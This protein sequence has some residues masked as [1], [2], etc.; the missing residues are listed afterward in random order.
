MIPEFVRSLAR[1]RFGGPAGGYADQEQARIEGNV[2]GDFLAIEATGVV[3]SCANLWEMAG[4]GARI[5]TESP[6]ARIRH[7]FGISS[8]LCWYWT[9]IGSRYPLW[10]VRRYARRVFG[11]FQERLL[12]VHRATLTW[13]A[14]G[15]RAPTSASRRCSVNAVQR[16]SSYPGSRHSGSRCRFASTSAKTLA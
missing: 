3:Q 6:L 8:S 2:H 11:P 14:N 15:G 4:R 12:P 13:I 5:A 10:V 7:R 9:R 1:K 16:W